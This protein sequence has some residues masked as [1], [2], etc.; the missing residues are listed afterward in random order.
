[1]L[2]H[3]GATVPFTLSPSLFLSLFLSFSPCS[4]LEPPCSDVSCECH[5]K[6]AELG[7]T[8][9]K[10]WRVGFPPSLLPCILPL[11]SPAP[12]PASPLPLVKGCS[13][14]FNQSLGLAFLD[15]AGSLFQAL[16]PAG[17][18]P[19]QLPGFSFPWMIL[20]NSCSQLPSF[21]P[22]VTQG[23]GTPQTLRVLALRLPFVW[24][25]HPRACSPGLES[26][27]IQRML[28]S[29]GC[30]RGVGR[31]EQRI[32]SLRL[33]GERSSGIL[34]VNSD[35]ESVTAGAVPA[36]AVMDAPQAPSLSPFFC[37]S[38]GEQESHSKGKGNIPLSLPGCCLME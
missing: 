30:R 10:L 33:G 19:H 24:Q 20:A 12:C 36:L 18:T 11:P 14:N 4:H 29:V 38:S 26:L 1:M 37:S 17:H 13:L 23:P 9:M 3:F 25:G 32:C 2:L 8:K 34:E 7:K 5:G 27:P 21:A 22:R 15:S 16:L 28:V 35:L 6:A 31:G